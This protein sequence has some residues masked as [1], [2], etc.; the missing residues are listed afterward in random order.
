VTATAIPFLDVVGIT[1]LMAEE[2]ELVWKTVLTHGRYVA[3]PEVEAFEQDFANFCGCPASVGVGNGTDALELIFAGLDIGPGDEVIVPANTFVAT[4]EAVC[5][6]GARPRF[7]DVLPDTLEVDPDAVA[8]AVNPRTA[9]VVAVHLYGQPAD[10]ERLQAVTQRHD[11]A[12]IED[13]AQAHGARFAGRRT[14]S[15]GI[16]AAFSFYPGKNLGALGD[17]GAVVSHDPSLIERIRS[18]ANHGRAAD[19]WHDH[20]LRGRNSRLDTLQAAVLSAKLRH[21]D[22]HN[23]RRRAL[24]SSYRRGLP[25]ACVVPAE[26]PLAEPVHHLAVVQVP[27][28]DAA[29]AALDAAGIGWGVHY[30]VPCHRQ[31]AFRDFAD[32]PLP[33]TERA[34]ARILSLPMSPTLVPAHVE[35]V[36]AVLQEVHR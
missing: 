36:C 9:A 22:A 27:D 35:R 28:R 8:A 31:P 13:A 3:G 16:A 5:R 18:L 32:G 12:L 10:M 34:A 24:M 33:V 6:A 15:L 20:D 23:A 21:L 26:H 17:G 11:L 7:V 4:A 14:G 2:L 30:P 25:D 1:E 19:G 29:T